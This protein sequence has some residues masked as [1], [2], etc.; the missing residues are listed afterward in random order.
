M[1]STDLKTTSQAIPTR[2]VELSD[3]SQIPSDY[4]STPGGTWFSTTPGGTRIVYDRSKLLLL[5]NS[6]LAKSPPKNLPRIPGVTCPADP[7]PPTTIA[8]A[9]EPTT[10]RESEHAPPTV[11]Q[12]Q[13]D[14]EM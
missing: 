5:R 9:P 10:T 13:F 11:E 6:P 7:K 8:E 1:S 14:M 12:D 3:P 4:S 2:R